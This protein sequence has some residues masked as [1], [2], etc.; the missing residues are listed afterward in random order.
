MKLFKTI[1]QK[2]EDLE[3]KKI[4]DNQWKYLCWINL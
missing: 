3:F 4:D 1:D 2:I